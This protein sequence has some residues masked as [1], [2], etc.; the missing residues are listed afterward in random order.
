MRSL[1]WALVLG[2]AVQAVPL[3][4]QET[5][6]TAR[7]ED[8]IPDSAVAD[9]DGWATQS[10]GAAD[11]A[12][13]QL[14]DAVAA[15]DAPLEEL[16]ELTVEWPEDL[17]LPDPEPLA[18]EEQ[19]AG[20]SLLADAE[21][22]RLPPAL[23]M[24]DRELGRN[25]V[26]GFPQDQA[27]FPE[28][29]EFLSRFRALSRVMALNG[30]V[31]QLAQ[32]AA[33]ARAD[34]DLLQDLLGIYGYYDGQVIR[35]LAAIQPGEE[36]ADVTPRVRFD[37]LPGQ[38]YTVGVIDLGRLDTAPDHDSL[39]A[40]FEVQHGD[41]LASDRI[42]AER[43]DLDRALG[44][45]GYP[46]ARIADPGLLIDHA[47]GE[48][49]LTMPVDPGGKYVFGQIT[50]NLPEFLSGKHLQDIARFDPGDTYQRSLE[51]DLR[52]AIVATNLVSS[53]MIEM[54]EV[55]P[56]ANGQ[57]GVVDADVKMEK[58]A[59]RTIAGAVGYGTEDGAKLEA[60]WTHR[61]LFPPEGALRIRGIVGTREQLASVSFTRNNF[62]ARD[63]VLTLD[64]YGSDIKTEAV[65]ARTLALHGSFERVSNLLFQK[66]FAWAVGAEALYSDER[67]RVIGGIARPRQEY[68][69]GSV[70]GR[71][72]IDGSDSLLDP[73]KGFRASL[74]LAPEFSRSSSSE[75]V[76]LRGQIDASVYQPVGNGI[77]LAA[78]SRVGTI[79][80]ARTYQIAPSR[81]LYAGGANSVR[82]YGYQ[83]VGPRNDLGEP[84]GGRS[85]V[86]F[87]AE[88]RIDTG[89]L[90][91]SLQVVP[92]FDLGTVGLDST[93]NFRFVSYGAG[94][95][96]RYKTGF[97]PV[98]VDV[99]VPL[100]RNP[101]FDSPIAVYV[102]LGQAF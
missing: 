82:G 45:S 25:L 51:N 21:E 63:H 24:V 86:E 46:F 39:R 13:Q 26:L 22:L 102:S 101:M 52:R 41:P 59:L 57:P 49:D 97:G 93:P 94:V 23:Q 16:P 70:F 83:A 61:N 67:N 65:E 91:D 66:S 14:G 35:T 53:T 34:H 68:L 90:D 7:L 89:L 36:T 98:R 64:L 99:G 60:S 77:I 75:I 47:R 3:R 74:L 38:R 54:R 18:A 27:G 88:V 58:G 6:A 69:I 32:L 72:S 79:Q 76:Y 96:L 92:F 73:T 29:T 55:T 56:P 9:P 62:H 8:L 40:A 1:A 5:A 42:E 20:A 87:S 12:D 81:R 50:S 85:L 33:R 28:Q 95:G 43:L 71:G 78:R 80:G 48:G 30:D 100:N 44:E 37:I 19:E 84:T 10:D 15:P 2:L 4:A 31:D 17:Q 11:I